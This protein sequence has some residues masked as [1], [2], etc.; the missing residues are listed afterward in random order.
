MMLRFAS[1][2]V[3]LGM[4]VSAYADD[5]AVSSDALNDVTYA[6][7]ISRIVQANCEGCHRPDSIGP[8]A[9]QSYRQVKGWS[10]MIRE[11]VDAG[12]M[13]PWHADAPHGHFRND[14]RLT[15]TQ[16]AQL[17]HWIDNGMPRGDAADMPEPIDYSEQGEWQFGEPDMVFEMPESVDV[18]ATGVVPYLYFQTTV[19]FEKDMYLRAA[20][21][22]PG[23]GSVV[24]HIVATWVLPDGRNPEWQGPNNGIIVG[25]A[26]G[27]IP[28]EASEGLARVIPKGADIAWQLHYTPTGKPETDRSKVALWFNEEPPTYV[29]QTGRPWNRDIRI[30]AHAENFYVEA[31]ETIQRDRYVTSFMPH[32]HYRGKSFR[33]TAIHPDGTKEVLL[34]VPNYDFAWQSQYRLAEPKFLPAG[35]TIHCEATYDNSANNPYNPDPTIAVTWGD[36]TWEEMMI[37]WHNYY[38]KTPVVNVGARTSD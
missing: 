1:V 7:H 5:A 37:G 22:L 26:P 20:E 11:V 28:F 31:K 9:M 18:P 12:R 14:R 38:E 30:P 4:T 27:D 8:F 32:M 23:N 13:P 19:N 10:K 35:T 3:A 21:A 33:Y 17:I 29:V 2:A 24:H 34:D 6:K 16:K 15:P 36:Q 25:Q